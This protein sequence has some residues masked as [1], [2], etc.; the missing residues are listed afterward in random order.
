MTKEPSVYILTNFTHTVLYVGVT[1]DIRKRVW[2]HK[3][4][5]V[6]GFTQQYNVDKLIY[7]EFLPSMKDAILREKQLKKWSRAKKEHLINTRNPE[8]NDLYQEL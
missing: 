7:F 6:K 2:Q 3:H 5:I 4:K 8:Y 1:S